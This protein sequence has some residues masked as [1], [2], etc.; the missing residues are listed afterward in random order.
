MAEALK[1]KPFEAESDSP[2]LISEPF[3]LSQEQVEEVV[4]GL[5]EAGEEVQKHLGAGEGFVVGG[6]ALSIGFEP[7]VQAQGQWWS[8]TIRKMPD[9]PV[10]LPGRLL[11]MLAAKDPVQDFSDSEEQWLLSDLQ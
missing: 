5:E 11:K 1:F 7:E 4:E 8:V 2:L 3:L 9:R 6:Q 10:R